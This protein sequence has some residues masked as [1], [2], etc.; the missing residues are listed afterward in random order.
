MSSTPTTPETRLPLVSQ[1]APEAA[2][3][4][5][6]KPAVDEATLLHKQLVRGPFWRKIPAYANVDEPTFLDHK[7]QAKNTI[8]NIKKLLETVQDLVSAD[9]FSDAEGGFRRAPM[10][11]RVSPYLLSLI[12]WGDPYR[13]PLRRQFIPLESRLLPDHP[14]LG[15]DSL[16]EQADAPVAGL[17]HRYVDKALFLPLDTCPVY[18]RFCTRSFAF[19]FDT[20]VVDL[21]KL[22]VFEERCRQAYSLIGS[23]T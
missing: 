18:C 15:L 17:T 19:G 2:V 8:T 7:W 23:G 9:F 12:D 16:G 6:L 10:S 13:D 20:Y 3:A 1:S 22:I 14:K 5:A 4:R 21:V 11:V